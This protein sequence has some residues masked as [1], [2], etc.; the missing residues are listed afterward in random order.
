MID[1]LWSFWVQPVIRFRAYDDRP[2]N[3]CAQMPLRDSRK[4]CAEI[5]SVV[6][7]MVAG[8]GPIWRWWGRT[9]NK[10]I[11]SLFFINKPTHPRVP[12]N[13]AMPNATFIHPGDESYNALSAF[14]ST[15]SASGEIKTCIKNDIT[16][17]KFHKKARVL[18][19]QNDVV[20]FVC[21]VVVMVHFFKLKIEYVALVFLSRKKL[22]I[23]NLRKLQIYNQ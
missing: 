2:T 19:T 22:F 13:T 17:N 1:S 3:E 14:G 20:G 6:E 12:P 18:I 5:G 9:I 7:S 4:A 8:P 16:P 11:E 23:D 10:G 21:S 15:S